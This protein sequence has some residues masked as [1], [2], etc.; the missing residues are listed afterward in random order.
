M[1]KITRKIIKTTRPDGSAVGEE[2]SKQRRWQIRNPKKAKGIR[3][4]FQKSPKYR[5]YLK[6]YRQTPKY[7]KYSREYKR[8]YRAKKR[9]D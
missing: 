2:V 3:D 1:S 5:E 9:K 7:R 8:K 6:K 4:R